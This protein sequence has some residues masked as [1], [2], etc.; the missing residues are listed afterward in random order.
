MSHTLPMLAFPLAVLAHALIVWGFCLMLVHALT[1][2]L[3]AVM[4][5]ARGGCWLLCGRRCGR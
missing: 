1:M 2:P 3:W 4:S 5:L